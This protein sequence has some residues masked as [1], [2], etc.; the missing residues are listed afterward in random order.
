MYRSMDIGKNKKFKINKN[1]C[2]KNL[3]KKITSPKKKQFDPLKKKFNRPPSKKNLLPNNNKMLEPTFQKK[4]INKSYPSI[5]FFSLD[6]ND[7]TIRSGP[8]IHCLPYARFY[9]ETPS[10]RRKFYTL[11]PFPK[12]CL[13]FSKHIRENSES[14]GIC[15]KLCE[16]FDKV[17]NKFSLWTFL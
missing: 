16:S 14:L 17:F 8:E 5:K 12:T 1:Y 2:N 6:G 9:I 10:D 15:P 7:D 4:I 11:I 13:D 3:K